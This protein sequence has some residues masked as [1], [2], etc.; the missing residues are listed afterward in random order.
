MAKR[1]RLWPAFTTGSD[2]ASNTADL[3]EVKALLEELSSKVN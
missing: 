1:A 2:K 3:G